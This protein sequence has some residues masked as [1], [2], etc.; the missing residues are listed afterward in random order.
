MFSLFW[1]QVNCS[2]RTV[3]KKSIIKSAAVKYKILNGCS[4]LDRARVMEILDEVQLRNKLHVNHIYY[5]SSHMPTLS[6]ADSM[7][8]SPRIP[9][10]VKVPPQAD[11]PFKEA[12]AGIPSLTNSSTDINEL[13][14]LFWTQTRVRGPEREAI[15][16]KM[17]D[18]F[19]KLLRDC[20]S[21]EDRTKFLLATEIGREINNYHVS[22]MFNSVQSME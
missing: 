16:F 11:A 6:G 5:N 13:C 18:L 20:V 9:P 14:A 8:A 3:L 21:E 12:I 2:K 4:V 10:L 17:I 7:T 1:S 15:F 22:D 19:A